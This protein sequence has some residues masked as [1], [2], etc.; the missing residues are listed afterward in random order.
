M[1]A[2]A[3]GIL[4][5]HPLN[6]FKNLDD[7]SHY[8]NVAF[9]VPEY[10]K[11]LWKR[12]YCITNDLWALSENDRLSEAN[13]MIKVSSQWESELDWLVRAMSEWVSYLND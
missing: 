3:R 5:F 11:N 2:S 7:L 10:Y 4:D 9:T 1:A 12:S 8:S 13:W 6:K